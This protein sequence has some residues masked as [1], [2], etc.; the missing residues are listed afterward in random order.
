[1]CKIELKKHFYIFFMY[2]SNQ[3]NVATL[4]NNLNKNKNSHWVL[5]CN[6]M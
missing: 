1:M 5:M 2:Y 4:G 6:R 3:L